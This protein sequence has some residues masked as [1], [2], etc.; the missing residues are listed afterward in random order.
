MNKWSKIFG[1]NC[2]YIKHKPEVLMAYSLYGMVYS[3]KYNITHF[4]EIIK[5]ISKNLNIKK[6]S[7]LL[8]FGSGNGAFLSLLINNFSLKKNISIE[9][10]NYFLNFQKKF[11]KSTK[12]Y[13][14]NSSKDLK[15]I[16]TNSVDNI[17]CNSVFQ[18]FSNEKVAQDILLEFVRICKKRIL[19]YVILDDA[20]K[21]KY[22]KEVR[23]RQ[24]LSSYKFKKKYKY[25]PI[26][27]YSRSFFLK[28][29]HLKNVTKSIKIINLPKNSL[30]SK[31]AYC[32]V[33]KKK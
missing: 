12:F 4:I 2:N 30:D 6:K 1:K 27:F 8:D 29:Q 13:L 24:N 18:Y 31:F 28:N 3:Y 14:G 15:K 19:I 22:K 26:R 17:M 20:K 7:S 16:K 25:T 10:N 11:I 9:I 23:L 5:F 33:I 21:I 32:C